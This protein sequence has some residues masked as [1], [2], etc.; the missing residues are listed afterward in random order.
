MWL[1]LM[2]GII[3]CL[4]IFESR[5]TGTYS[6]SG[7]MARFSKGLD[8]LLL[9]LPL[10][11]AAVFAVLFL[12]VLKG[13]FYERL[14]HAA[15]VLACWL[16]AARFYWMLLSFFKH[17]WIP[18]MSVFGMTGSVAAAIVLTPLDRY[19]DLV[20]SYIGAGSILIG[21]ALLFIYY[22]VRLLFPPGRAAKPEQP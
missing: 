20:H 17:K 2:L 16:Y 10:L 18:A 1:F 6:V 7:R 8:R 13:R 15:L 22:A 14:S 3:A 11:A 12:L 21:G 5:R 19:V 9:L 4:F